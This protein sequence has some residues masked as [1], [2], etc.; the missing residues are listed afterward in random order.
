MLQL[1]KVYNTLLN[2]DTDYSST[3]GK[4][5]YEFLCDK[6]GGDVEIGS[7]LILCYFAKFEFENPDDIKKFMEIKKLLEYFKTVGEDINTASSFGIVVTEADNFIEML[8]GHRNSGNIYKMSQEELYN[9]TGAL[10]LECTP[11][12][13]K[14]TSLDDLLYYNIYD[15]N[16]IRLMQTLYFVNVSKG[17]LLKKVNEKQVRLSDIDSVRNDYGRAN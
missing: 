17:D 8:R 5:K 15:R 3:V 9:T 4:T 13:A 16:M 2:L 7:T 6:L 12:H 10:H 14:F 1:D 11:E